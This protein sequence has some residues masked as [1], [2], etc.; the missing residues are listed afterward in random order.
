[1]AGSGSVRKPPRQLSRQNQERRVCC[2][3][4]CFPCY[5]HFS[6]LLDTSEFHEE[7]RLLGSDEQLSGLGGEQGDL[8][9]DLGRL[10]SPVCTVGQDPFH[11]RGLPK[12]GTFSRK[13]TLVL[14]QS[15]TLVALGQDFFWFQRSSGMRKAIQDQLFLCAFP[16]SPGNTDSSRLFTRFPIVTLLPYCVSVSPVLIL[17]FFGPTC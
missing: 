4:S 16:G 12:I 17:R 9:W 7:H 5:S 14:L 3:G 2:S 11:G 15:A 8:T 1:M 6:V 10:G 13:T